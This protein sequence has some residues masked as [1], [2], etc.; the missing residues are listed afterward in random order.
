MGQKCRDPCDQACGTRATCS[1]VD[2]RAICACE[3]GLE[4]DPFQGC[5]TPKGNVPFKHIFLNISIK[6]FAEFFILKI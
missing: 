5:S 6:Y 4:G 2:H 3:S 1:V